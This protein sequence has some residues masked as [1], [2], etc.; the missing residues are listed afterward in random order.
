MLQDLLLELRRLAQV[1]LEGLGLDLLDGL[2]AHIAAVLGGTGGY[3]G[4]IAAGS[5]S[6]RNS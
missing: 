2:Y 3:T 6:L 4:L 5:R 1:A